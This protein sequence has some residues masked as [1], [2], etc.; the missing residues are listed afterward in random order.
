MLTDKLVHFFCCYT[1]IL[2]IVR[3]P[4]RT[5]Q[6]RR[7]QGKSLSFG[8][9]AVT[10]GAGFLGTEV[11]RQLQSAGFEVIVIDC[12]IPSHPSFR[13]KNVSYYQLD[14]L[15]KDSSSKL[16]QLFR[17]CVAVCHTAGVVCLADDPGLLFNV[18]VVATQVVLRAARL[19]GVKAFVQT[20]STGA[21][22]S[23]YISSNQQQNIPSNFQVSLPV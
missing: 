22:T 2:L 15:G 4:V 7:P 12:R 17:D 19:A 8:K 1:H 5:K 6:Q 10:G 21:I 11:V 18:H 20:S 16:Q 9:V 14:L 23:P 3:V 13:E